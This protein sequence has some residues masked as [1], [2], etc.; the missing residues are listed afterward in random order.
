MSGI[1]DPKSRVLDTIITNEGKWQ[2]A[3]GKFNIQYVSFSDSSTFYSFDVASGSS[4][5][6]NR[7]YL[8]CSN[9]PQDQITFE[10]DDNGKLI[11][12]NGSSGLS[13]ATGK[14]LTSSAV[15]FKILS[16]SD[17]SSASQEIVSTSINNFQKLL[18]IGTIDSVFDDQQFEISHNSISF[19]ITNT[20]PIAEETEQTANVNQLDSF[21]YDEKLSNI[22]N[23]SFLP[24]LNKITNLNTDPTDQ[25]VQKQYSLGEYK[26]IGSTKK[27]T[28]DDINQN[29]EKLRQKG[30]VISLKFDPTTRYNNLM[31]QVFEQKTNELKKLDVLNFGKFIVSDQE[32][33]E[34]QVFFVGKVFED[35]FGTHTFVKLFTLIF[36]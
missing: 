7:V 4:D 2:L 3:R 14:I 20:N 11:A 31:C 15:G 23:F 24:P 5:A 22:S 30:N 9:L 19:K 29:V 26:A 34:R 35:D 12:M 28:F 32:N 17:F 13:I 1:L 21:F 36:R 10:T 33:P 27:L 16:G 18:P 6:S 8:E 25:A